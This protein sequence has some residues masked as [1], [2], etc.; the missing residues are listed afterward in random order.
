MS[1]PHYATP[2]ALRAVVTD[3][4]RTLANAQGTQLNDLLRQFAY[5]RFLALFED[6]PERWLLKGA[7]AMLAR[8]GPDS[9]HTLD[10]DLYRSAGSL[11]EAEVALRTSAALDLGDFF[12]FEIAPGSPWPDQW[13]RVSSQSPRISARPYSGRSLSTS[14]PS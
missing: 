10:V 4:L 8:L 12:R 2:Q 5:D 6:D 1:S 9:R 13:R 14:S 7:T 11:D 3:R